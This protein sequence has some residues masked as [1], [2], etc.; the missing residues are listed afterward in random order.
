MLIQ[1]SMD[2]HDVDASTH[3]RVCVCVFEMIYIHN[4]D[5]SKHVFVRV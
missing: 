3:M 5:T 1:F 4:V 2:I